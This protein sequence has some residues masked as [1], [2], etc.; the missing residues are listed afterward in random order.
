MSRKIILSMHISINGMVAGPNGEMDWITTDDGVFDLVGNL[1]NHADAAIYGRRTYEM[2]EAYWPTA[3]KKAEATRH[4]KKHAEWYRNA[5]KIILSKSMKYRRISNTRFVS[6]NIAAEITRI[7]NDDGGDILLFGSP[8]AA[9]ELMNGNLI[10]DYWLFVY[11]VVIG[12]GIALFSEELKINLTLV[13]TKL[14][15]SGIV[16]LHYSI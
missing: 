10:D 11:P 13:E 12:D 4:D 8:S 3:D 14:F 7:K 16:G 1:T 6:E 2:M 9:R 5:R 15:T